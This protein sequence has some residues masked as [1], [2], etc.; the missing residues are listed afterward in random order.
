MLRLKKSDKSIASS[1]KAVLF[2]NPSRKGRGALFL[3]L[4]GQDTISGTAK[5]ILLCVLIAR[6]VHGNLKTDTKGDTRSAQRLVNSESVSRR[7]SSPPTQ[8]LPTAMVSVDG[9]NISGSG[10]VD[11]IISCHLHTVH[12]IPFL[13]HRFLVFM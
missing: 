4:T 12:L 1:S 13:H 5:N 8:R 6:N 9:R 3:L 2:T 10:W 7:T 11:K